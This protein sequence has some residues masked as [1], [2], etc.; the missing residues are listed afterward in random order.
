MRILHVLP[1]YFPA[2]R[3]GGPIYSVH[4]LARALKRRGHEVHVYTTNVD[5]E[6]VSPVPLRRPVDID[7]VQVWYFPTEFGRRIYRS[8]AM[9]RA[10]RNNLAAFDILHTHSV[11]LW[12]TSAAAYTA[13]QCGV[14]YIL[15]PR[16][17]LVANLIRRKNPMVKQLWIALC[18]RRNIE[19]AA[20]IQFT[21]Q[22]EA[23]EF[24][25]FG[26]RAQDSA[27]VPNGIDVPPAEANSCRTDK[28]FHASHPYILYLGRISWKKRLDELIRAM[29]Q[30]PD[31]ALVIAGNDDESLQPNLE[32]L[33][34][35]CG[36]SNRV[37]FVGFVDGKRKWDLFREA[38]AFVLPSESENFGVAVLEAMSVGCPVIVTSGVGLSSSIQETGAGLVIQADP[39]AIANAINILMTNA[40][41]RRSMGERGR[42]AARELFSWD[43]IAHQ[44]ENLYMRHCTSGRRNLVSQH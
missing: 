9:G 25:A 21:S 13:R 3:Y 4:A 32:K 44:T 20:A 29:I 27:I 6:S 38:R 31:I 35:Q 2:V 43:A 30:L 1:S 28:Q 17:M 10:F 16:G 14:P 37:Q 34:R 26:F 8:P 42:R 36:I 5:G 22:V 40:E 33:A 15:A 11:F 7:G 23:D 24:R 18:E 12:P 41:M 19:N 39:G